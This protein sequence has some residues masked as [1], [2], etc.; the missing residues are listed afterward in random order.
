MRVG[1]G[2]DAHRF[3]EPRD[4][5]AI[6]L[7]GVAV[8]HTHE[9]IAH[10]DGDVIIHALCDALLGALSLGDIGS[11]FPDT[12]PRWQDAD[13]RLLMRACYDL[14]R[15]RGLSLAN[16]DITL[17]AERPRVRDHVEEMRIVLATDLDVEQDRISI[18]ATTTETMGFIGRQ[19]GLAAQAAVLLL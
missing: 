15:A 4:H 3:G 5:H 19:E 9:I 6:M 7:G 17:I 2:F 8:P 1:F 18:K 14:A 16:A 12:D 11:H 10:S 13:S